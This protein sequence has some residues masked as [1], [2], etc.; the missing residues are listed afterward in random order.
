MSL[1]V[2]CPAC[3]CVFRDCGEGSCSNCD[4]EPYQGDDDDFDYLEL[5]EAKK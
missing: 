5:R 4:W 1:L 3:G 2:E